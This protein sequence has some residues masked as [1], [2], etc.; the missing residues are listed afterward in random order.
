VVSAHLTFSVLQRP[1][2]C[3]GGVL[4]R[5]VHDQVLRDARWTARWREMSTHLRVSKY[6]WLL[7]IASLLTL[8]LTK[9]LNSFT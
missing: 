7:C 6:T 9:Q 4:H 1:W 2:S 8:Q 5:V 3:V